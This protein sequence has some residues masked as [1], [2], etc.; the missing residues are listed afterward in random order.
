MRKLLAPVL[1]TAA[2][3]CAQAYRDL[4]LPRARSI[5]G[6]VSGVDGKPIGEA[7]I[8]HSD[9]GRETIQT[10]AKGKFN[11]YTR[12]PAV[13]LRKVGYR[14]R[15]LRT[16]DISDTPIILQPAD[17][18]LQ[19]PACR[20]VDEADARLLDRVLDGVCILSKQR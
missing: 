14:S 19:I 2:L 1:L 10:D 12:A 9:S 13:V 17:S 4:L 15:W 11:F 20:N 7:R 16:A 8:E 18:N 5:T 3:L 6:I